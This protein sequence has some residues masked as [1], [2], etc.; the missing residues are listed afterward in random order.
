MTP[1]RH[2]I[3]NYRPLRVGVELA[4]GS[5]IYSAGVGTVVVDP[6]VDGKTI[7]SVELTRVLHVP[8][9]RSN[10]LSCLF[11][12]RCCSF[13]ILIDAAF[14]HF[15]RSATRTAVESANALKTRPLDLQLWHERLCH[16]NTT[17]ISKLISG[18]LATGISLSS[19]AKQDPICEPSRIAPSQSRSGCHVGH[20]VTT[21]P[22][23]ASWAYRPIATAST[24]S[25][26]HSKTPA[27]V[28]LP[29]PVLLPWPVPTTSL[30]PHPVVHTSASTSVG[31]TPI[32]QLAKRPNRPHHTTS[33]LPITSPTPN[34]APHRSLPPAHTTPPQL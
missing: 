16:H 30:A 15:M 34:T 22:A 31:S 23:P 5:I 8:Q 21:P 26:G 9:L 12:T 11:L 28:K 14:M 7:R 18:G 29:I 6:V 17:D 20:V 33:S 19:S 3:R 27:S 25:I 1:H 2:W 24:S 32:P 13:S 10:L 4:D